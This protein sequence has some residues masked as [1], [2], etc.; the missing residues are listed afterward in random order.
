MRKIITVKDKSGIFINKVSGTIRT[1]DIFAHLINATLNLT[2]VPV[3]WDFTDADIGKITYE[4]LVKMVKKLKPYAELRS[5]ARTAIVASYDLPFD[6]VKVLNELAESYQSSIQFKGFREID[7]AKE[8]LS[9][10]L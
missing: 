7:Q 6:M 1:E 2:N 9:S 10:P 3:L 5:G 4:E 8:W